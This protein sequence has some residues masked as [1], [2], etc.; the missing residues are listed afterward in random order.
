MPSQGKG[1]Q[2]GEVLGRGG[3]P[4]LRSD[5]SPAL[6]EQKLG[7]VRGKCFRWEYVL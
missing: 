1:L 7:N 2:S 5:E 4:H 3:R 6:K